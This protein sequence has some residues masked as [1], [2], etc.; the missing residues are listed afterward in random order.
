MP[1]GSL[2]HVGRRVLPGVLAAMLLIV[3]AGF[4]QPSPD[5][6]GDGVPDARIPVLPYR[7]PSKP[8]PMGT[9]LVMPAI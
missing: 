6:D 7:I 4:A 3:P 9:A 1:Y 2:S 8:I 5:L